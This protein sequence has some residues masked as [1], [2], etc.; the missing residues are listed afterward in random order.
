MH[1]DNVDNVT[2]NYKVEQP[3]GPQ[4]SR[5]ETSPKPTIQDIFGPDNID[6]LLQEEK[7]YEAY[8]ASLRQR[9]FDPAVFEFKDLVNHYRCC[10][11]VGEAEKAVRTRDQLT[12]I[13][14][15][16]IQTT[17]NEIKMLADESRREG[18]VME[19]ILFYR[20]AADLYR[21]QPRASLVHV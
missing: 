16:N 18:K 14:E 13:I 15:R 19:A 20:T 2:H 7:Y 4:E 3:S 10:M 8:V 11:L 6:Q 5:G 9:E 1:I 12:T 21:N 17:P